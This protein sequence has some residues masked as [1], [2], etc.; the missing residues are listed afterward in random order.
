[1]NAVLRR[2]LAAI[3]L[4][5]AWGLPPGLNAAPA[6]NGPINSPAT[7]PVY[8]VPIQG[9]ISQARFFFLRRALKEAQSD[10]ARAVILDMNTPG[11]SLDACVEMQKALAQ[12]KPR[13]IT[14]VNTQAG[15]AGAL[16]AVSTKE[17]YMAPMSAIGAAAPVLPGGQEIPETLRDKSISFFSNYFRSVAEANG[18]N[19]DIAQ[20]FIDRNKAVIIDG[21]TIHE[22]GSVLTLSAQEAVKEIGGKRVLAAG[23]ADSIPSIL[24]QAGLEGATIKQMEPAG[25][26]VL[27]F[28]LTTLAPLLL[29]GGILGA[30]L[31]FKMPGFGLP[32]ITSV[33]CFSL[34]FLGHY[35]AGLAGWEAPVVFLVGL[36]LVLG[37]LFIHP[38]TILPGL[39]GLV[40]MLGAVIWA[41]VD[42]YPGTPLLPS[43]AAL[44]LP[45]A[46]LG[47]SVILA[48]IV[49]AILA[50][51]LPK[52]SFF[53]RLVLETGQHVGASLPVGKS[54]YT[55]LSAGDEGVTRS[56][57]RPSGKAEFRGELY[58][59]LTSGQFVDPGMRVRVVAVEGSRIVVEPMG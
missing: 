27:G 24:K 30:Y 52:S 6:Q 34:F 46:K 59:V 14:Y 43:T 5:A 13:T 51:Y 33:I 55:R 47:G 54:E 50:K 28:W 53:G 19:P 17:I 8:V 42:R 3:T 4:A 26:E 23:V 38:G 2:I 45:L 21:Q 29:L 7:G 36:A 25:F 22:K 9:E 18:H 49:I 44:L 48:G 31:E 57:L 16:I 58:D 40:L 37:E 1:M 11:G 20:A 10:G 39:A 35:L 15:S 41:M 32:G 12:A 56:I